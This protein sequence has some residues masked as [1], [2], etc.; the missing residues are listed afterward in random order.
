MTEKIFTIGDKEWVL[1]D[2]DV[3]PHFV[4]LLTEVRQIDGLVYLTFAATTVDGQN[5]GEVQVAA[6]LRMSLRTAQFLRNMLAETI[7]GRKNG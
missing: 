7:E 3:P 5:T 4:D 1:V 6:R 2:R